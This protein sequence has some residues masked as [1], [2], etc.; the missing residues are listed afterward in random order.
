MYMYIII[1]VKS[2][3]ITRKVFNLL[4][5]TRAGKGK[6]SSKML[7]ETMPHIYVYTCMSMMYGFDMCQSLYILC[8]KGI[9]DTASDYHNIIQ[10]NY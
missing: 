3:Y 1:G 7:T 6:Y 5:S 8:F 9:I 4:A 10:L 2:L